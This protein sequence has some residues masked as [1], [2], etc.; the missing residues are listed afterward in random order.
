MAKT[1]LVTGGARSG[2]SRY[3]L[4]MAESLSPRRVYIATCPLMD[5]DEM[6]DR[7]ARHR[8]DRATRDWQTIEEPTDLAGALRTITGPG[9][10]LVDCLTLWVNNL[11]HQ[12]HKT[13]RDLDED[14]VASRCHEVLAACRDREAAV[15]FVT[16]EV[17]MG[18]VPDNEPA[19]R[20]RDLVGRSNQVIA[21]GADVVTLVTC[22]I[23]LQLK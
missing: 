23:P 18:I 22:G 16:N 5:D 6:R 21:A 2:K 7:I 1:I 20:Y 3:A 11:M 10:V 12:A 19:R 17:G 8:R 4:A 13:G 9:V 14:A 15:I